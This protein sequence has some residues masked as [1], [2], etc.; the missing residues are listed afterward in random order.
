M[1]IIYQC[2]DMMITQYTV[3]NAQQ[4]LFMDGAC[5]LENGYT[6]VSFIEYGKW[7]ITDKIFNFQADHTGFL[8][9]LVTPVEEN[10][11]FLTT[12]DLFVRFWITP[13]K[14][15]RIFGTKMFKRV[16]E[17]GLLSDTVEKEAKNTVEGL[18]TRIKEGSFP[19]V[20]I[21]EFKVEKKL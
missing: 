13:E 12:Q 8:T 3:E 16:S 18:I 14:E 2:N 1:E 17:E 4:P 11:T 7:Y 9:K 5:V 20:E 10:L 19:P 6:V 15:F 21:E